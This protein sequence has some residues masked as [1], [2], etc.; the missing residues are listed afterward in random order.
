MEQMKN[1]G[2]AELSK[3]VQRAYNEGQTDYYLEPLVQVDNQGQPL[4]RITSG[5]S[6]VFCCRRGEREIGLTEMFTDPNFNMVPRHF[7]KDLNFVTLTLYHEKFSHLPVAF[8]PTTISKTL[9]Q[10]ISEQGLTQLHCAESEKFAHV[11]FFF[12]GGNNAPYPGEESL[13]VPSPRGINYADKPELSLPEVVDKLLVRLGEHDFVLVNFANGDIIGHTLSEEAKISAAEHVSTQLERLVEE[14][15]RKDYV[16][17]ITADHGNLE[18]M[19]TKDGKPD[20]AHTR[21]LVPFILIDPRHDGPLPVKDGSLC[22]VAPTILSIMDLPKPNEMTGKSL[23]EQGV[24]GQGRKVLLIILDG[25]GFG[26]KDDTDPIHLAN[27]PYWDN[28]VTCYPPS[29]LHASDGFVGLGDGKPGNSEAGHLNLGA[30]RVVVQDDIRIDKA[31]ADGDFFQNEV[32]KKAM[33]ETKNRGKALHLLAYLTHNSSHG[34]IGYALAVLRM[35]KE[36]PN[37]FL[38]IIFDGRSTSPGSAPVL[39]DELDE[40][41]QVI[42]VGQVVG[43]I[44]RGFVLERD[45]Q[46]KKIKK[47]YDAMVLGHGTPYT[48]SQ[49]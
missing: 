32:L 17:I 4:G 6:V 44:G 11:T 37:V 12:N 27:T 42:G 22:D 45:K 31:I 3:A 29:S 10:V 7:L 18:V 9:A 13:L 15:K 43:G 30:G 20:M 25:W 8:P 48:R 28:L 26:A 33:E 39:L 49:E 19:T 47:G 46:Y 16:V 24:F 14:A 35:A 38:H 36:I 23:T 21:N 40:Q 5:D 34:S 1:H 41:L 2:V